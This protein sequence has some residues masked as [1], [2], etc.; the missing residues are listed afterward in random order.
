VYATVNEVCPAVA[1]N[2]VFSYFVFASTI[3]VVAV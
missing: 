3:N 2:V 1:V